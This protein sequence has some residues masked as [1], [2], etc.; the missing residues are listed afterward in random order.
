LIPSDEELDAKITEVCGNFVGQLDD[1]YAAVGLI[2][3]GRRFGWRV[4]RLVASRRH[5]SVA[6][7]LFG[8]PKTWMDQRGVFYRKSVALKIIDGV[9]DYW[10]FIRG[11]KAMAQDVKKAAEN[12][13]NDG[14]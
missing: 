6:V 10:A 2:V 4:M 12:V 14:C 9:G 11:H 13:V 7:K 1:L 3:V 8:D 5:W